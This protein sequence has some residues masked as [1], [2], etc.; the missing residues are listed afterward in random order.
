MG[1]EYVL[2]KCRCGG[3]AHLSKSCPWDQ[4]PSIYCDKCGGTWKF[5]TYSD[6]LTID[7]WNKTH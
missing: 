6:K 4:N 2:K 1:E 7:K 5:G 3:T